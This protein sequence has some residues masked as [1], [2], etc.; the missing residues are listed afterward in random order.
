MISAQLVLQMTE[1]DQEQ[2]LRPDFFF[3]QS[4][5]DTE[6]DLSRLADWHF[7]SGAEDDQFGK[8]GNSWENFAFVLEIVE[9]MEA[10]ICYP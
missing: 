8:M 5:A 9:S 7:P 1:I 3:G 6:L 2:L 10:E 4:F